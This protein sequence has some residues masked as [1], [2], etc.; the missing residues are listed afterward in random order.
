M[1]RRKL[2]DEDVTRIK[3]AIETYGGL[4]AAE[5]AMKAEFGYSFGSVQRVGQ[6]MKA[7]S[8]REAALA[9]QVRQHKGT[10][11]KLHETLGNWQML[12]EQFVDRAPDLPV[13]KSLAIKANPSKC[14]QE[15]VVMLSDSHAVEKW[16]LGQTDGYSEYSFDIF[17]NQLWYY[18]QEIIRIAHEDRAKYGLKVLH[19]DMLGDIYHGVLRLDDEV[20][21][22][23]ATVPGVVM[24][25]WVLYQWLLA[26]K[27]HFE[28]IEVTCMAG[29]HG[30]LHQKTQSKRYVEENRDTLIY[31]IVKQM[32]MANGAAGRI[33]VTVP[34][35]RKHTLTRLGHKIKLAHGDHIKGGGGIAG[36][37]VYGL[38]RD[39]LRQFKQLVRA[40]RHDGIDLFEIGHFHSS[41]IL[42][43]MFMNG[44]FCPTGPWAMD[45]LGAYSDPAQWVYYTSEQHVYGWNIPLSLK[46][47]ADQPNGFAYSLAE[48][49][50]GV[51]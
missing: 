19:V 10:S 31:L 9:A 50:E 2:T 7:D 36:I 24:T 30:R 45:E 39:L 44:A 4:R 20:T 18:A 42:D 34:N 26:L 11:K 49:M 22:E 41:N 51:A 1:A 37:P 23:F 48:L 28:R 6:G 46:H 3:A 35:S 13:P 12:V 47:G 33:N 25:S 5:R 43:G 15:M 29:N 21:N 40:G 8:P 17:A 27:P 14:P 38:S 32:V 16:G